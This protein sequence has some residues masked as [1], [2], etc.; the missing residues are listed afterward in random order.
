[1]AAVFP[2]C[3]F[4]VPELTHFGMSR[5]ETEEEFYSLLRFQLS[6]ARPARFVPWVWVLRREGRLD[7][8]TAGAGSIK[9]ADRAFGEV[10]GAKVID[11]RLSREGGTRQLRFRPKMGREAN[12]ETESA[13][14]KQSPSAVRCVLRC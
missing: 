9:V 6:L 3:Y 13:S 7:K 8:P 4:F 11:F 12:T 10:I 5:M 2:V 1:M 14:S